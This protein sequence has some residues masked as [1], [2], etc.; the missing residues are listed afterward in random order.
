M[1]MISDIFTQETQFVWMLGALSDLYKVHPSEDELLTELLLLGISKA[2]SVVGFL[3]PDLY[4]RLRKGLE[5]G[6]R[7]GQMSTRAACVH[8]LLYLLQRD[9]GVETPGFF[10]LAIDHLKA[11]MLGGRL[12]TE[13]SQHSLLLWSL[14]FFT[15]ENCEPDVLDSELSEALT[16]VALTTA[17]HTG[18]SRVL[19]TS[20]LGGLERLVVGGLIRGRM[21]ERLVKTVTDL[22]TDWPPVTVLPA[23]QLFLAAMYCSHPLTPGSRPTTLSDPETLMQM[24]EQMSILFDCV[25]RSGPPQAE[26]LAEILPQVLIDFFPASDVVN[27]VI[28]EFISPGQPH[29]ALLAGVLK[30]IFRAA[31]SQDQ[32][33]MLTEWVLVSLPNFAR[34]APL[35]HSIWCLS[36]FFLAASSNPWLQVEAEEIRITRPKCPE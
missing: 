6:L 12:M 7:S 20:V 10:M 26:L 21:L 18:L 36:C 23:L 27:R 19:Y 2:V 11:N 25:R 4:E 32:Q 33:N 24:M 17:G 1:L 13:V 30:N 28:S 3:E 5:T 35:S 16:Q 9:S 15:L 22:M 31:V 34:R 14:M 8:S 29:P